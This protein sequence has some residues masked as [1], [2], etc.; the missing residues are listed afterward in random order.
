MGSHF[1]DGIDYNEIDFNGIDYNG[2][3]FN[4]VVILI[5]LLELVGTFLG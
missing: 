3:D 2:I 1:Q 4:G 5:G